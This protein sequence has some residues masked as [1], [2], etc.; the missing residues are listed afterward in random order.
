MSEDFS[1][2]GSTPSSEFSFHQQTIGTY[3][4]G[5]EAAKFSQLSQDRHVVNQKFLNAL[6]KR[7]PQKSEFQTEL[8]TVTE[9][10]QAED[11]KRS[12]KD[13]VEEVFLRL[14][15]QTEQTQRGLPEELVLSR[16]SNEVS[17]DKVI[18]LSLEDNQDTSFRV[19]FLKKSNGVLSHSTGHIKDIIQDRSLSTRSAI[20]RRDTEKYKKVFQDGGGKY[21]DRG[22]SNPNLQRDTDVLYFEIG[23]PADYGDYV[24]SYSQDDLLIDSGLNVD[25]QRGTGYGE[26]AISDVVDS[27]IG[28]IPADG[29][30]NL[31]LS[32]EKAVICS[33]REKYSEMVQDLLKAG[34]SREWIL[35]HTF[36]FREHVSDK[37]VKVEVAEEIRRRLEML[38]SLSKDKSSLD[39]LGLENRR[40]G[41]NSELFRIR[42]KSVNQTNKEVADNK[43]KDQLKAEYLQRALKKGAQTFMAPTPVETGDIE[44]FDVGLMAERFPESRE[45]LIK[46]LSEED[47]KSPPKTVPEGNYQYAQ[48]IVDFVPLDKVVGG[49]YRTD[50]PTWLVDKPGE[51]RESRGS[52]R[53][54]EIIQWFKDGR[55]LSSSPNDTIR[56]EKYGD[57]YYI[58]GQGRHR[59]GALKAMGVKVIPMRII[60]ATPR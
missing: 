55:K 25:L 39:F 1:E 8:R 44:R 22:L 47:Q 38:G 36:S 9:E 60:E 21:G 31:A 45:E 37:K 15:A 53:I 14:N 48:P 59:I 28:E 19:D 16:A 32:L 4:L 11:V 7:L 20:Q 17:F 23:K 12:D 24:I 6:D 41:K 42:S 58:A 33:P 18:D 10:L 2:V 29:S 3:D 51:E 26:V 13:I 35:L 40:I 30:S 43:E 50:P 52:G 56:V 57:E 54:L 46:I 49:P 5:F 34:Y 27:N